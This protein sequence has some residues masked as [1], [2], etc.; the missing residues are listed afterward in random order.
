MFRLI[1]S[2]VFSFFILF[3]TTCLADEAE[4]E[5]LVV[6]EAA[7][8]M[9]VPPKN[10]D[11]ESVPEESVPEEN[12]K[13]ENEAV[14]N[15]AAPEVTEDAPEAKQEAPETQAEEPKE[16]ISEAELEARRAEEAELREAGVGEEPEA[17]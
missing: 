13:V 1:S 2:I 12:V 7:E 9:E 10:T 8:E 3:Q 6:P 16:K 11:E 14:E 15:E 17:E 5:P 4:H